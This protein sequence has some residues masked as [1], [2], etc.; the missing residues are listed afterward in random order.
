VSF[1]REMQQLALSRFPE[2]LHDRM[3]AIVR[4]ES[5]LLRNG[6]VAGLTALAQHLDRLRLSATAQAPRW[7]G[8]RLVVDVAAT[9]RYGDDDFRF[10]LDGDSWLVPEAWVPGVSAADRRWSADDEAELDIDFASIARADSALWSTTE[11]L[12]MRVDDTGRPT[13]GGTVSIDPAT[14]AGGSP[15]A[16]GV[17][18]FQMRVAFSGLQRSARVVP[19]PDAAT[20]AVASAADGRA[21]AFW[22]KKTSRLALRVGA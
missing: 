17:W 15:L 14:L 1:V 6:D 10:E 8:G 9:L 12:A 7:E 22:T 3:P 4:A 16:D 21:A 5:R 19:A 13:F 2:D 18:D 11:G 20:T